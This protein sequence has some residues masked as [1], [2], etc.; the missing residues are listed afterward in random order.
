[1]RN[2]K[3]GNHLKRA[4]PIRM[5]ETASSL[6][7]V[8][9]GGTGIWWR[10]GIIAS[11]SQMEQ[12]EQEAAMET[13]NIAI[14]TLAVFDTTQATVSPIASELINQL[15]KHKGKSSQT[16]SELKKYN[17]A[18]TKRV[19]N[20]NADDVDDIIDNAKT[21]KKRIGEFFDSEVTAFMKNTHGYDDLVT[22]L[23]NAKKWARG[24]TWF[25]TISGPLFDAAN[26][27]FCGWQLYNAIHDENSSPEVRS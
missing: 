8:Y 6:T 15:V 1:M 16:I 12:G 20:A 26:V 13:L 19:V 27:A 18:L 5:L 10:S 7:S 4:D 25:D 24:L 3:P 14:T 11:I 2:A 17:K 22:S 21:L 23:K 9:V